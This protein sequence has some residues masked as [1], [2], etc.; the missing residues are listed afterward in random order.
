MFKYI[1]LPTTWLALAL[2]CFLSPSVISFITENLTGVEIPWE[3][4]SYG[5]IGTLTLIG[6][7]L[8][9]PSRQ[10]VLASGGLIWVLAYFCLTALWSESEQYMRSK[11]ALTIAIPP[12]MFLSGLVIGRSVASFRTL[13]LSLIGLALMISI[14]MLVLGRDEVC[15]YGDEPGAGY[16]SVSRIL[17]LGIISCLALI[18]ID[19]G[20][21]EKASYTLLVVLFAFFSITSG[22]RVGLALCLAYGAAV[23]WFSRGVLRAAVLAVAFFG[24]VIFVS[25]QTD[26][27]L[28]DMSE[29]R[30]LPESLRRTAFYLSSA[31]EVKANEVSRSLLYNMGWQVWSQHSI[32]G[33]GWGGF[34]VAAGFGEDSGFYP[35]NLILELLAETGIVGG[36]FFAALVA[37]VSVPALWLAHPRRTPFVIVALGFLA[38]GLINAMI[39]FDFPFQRELMIGMGLTVSAAQ[40]ARREQFDE[41]SVDE[42]VHES[43]Q[44]LGAPHQ[45]E[46]VGPTSSDQAGSAAP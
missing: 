22:G 39:V 14:A 19:R 9:Y 16:Q 36:L 13:A 15:N 23:A 10:D 12:L 8:T 35:H 34:P 45:S 3:Y 42:P 40:L 2:A 11:V 31:S 24:L 30:S 18:W 5:L 17:G 7:C 32:L 44:E 1:F 26:M 41:S 28:I 38:A 33:T 4:I 37:L 43:E 46:L 21:V 27:W 29:S 25:P 20:W 6:L